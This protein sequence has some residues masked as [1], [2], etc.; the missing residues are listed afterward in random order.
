MAAFARPDDE[1][2][3]DVAALL[4]ELAA[5]IRT[6]SRTE[7]AIRKLMK[8][9]GTA[10]ARAAAVAIKEMESEDYFARARAV[11]ALGELAL[12]TPEILAALKKALGDRQGWVRRPA[13]RALGKLGVAA[14]EVV[15]ALIEGLKRGDTEC[16]E[17]IAAFGKDAKAAVPH[18]RVMMRDADWG[19]DRNKTGIAAAGALAR[20]V[21]VAEPRLIPALIAALRRERG[22]TFD[23][24]EVVRTLGEIGPAARVA[25]PYMH[26]FLRETEHLNP[27]IGMQAAEA[28]GNLGPAAVPALA[29]CLTAN[30][31][32]LLISIAI[33]KALRKNGDKSAIPALMVLR[34]DRS[35]GVR[36]NTIQTV[37]D[38]GPDGREA[39]PQLLA[40]LPDLGPLDRMAWAATVLSIDPGQS[41]VV[42]KALGDSLASPSPAI[43][44]GT[45]A[46]LL[47]GD[48]ATAKAGADV[49]R[50]GMKA[51]D[52]QTRL[53][54]IG[55]LGS[56]RDRAAG[57]LP[58]IT[59]LVDDPDPAVRLT[60][61]NA[62][63]ALTPAKKP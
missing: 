28:L 27:I 36:G 39:V 53:W 21:P 19:D 2:P 50:D 23:K 55:A 32:E 35:P 52:W 4:D 8:V 61:R 42:A 7:G 26:Q 60:A 3:T 25:I 34:L 6:K 22:D 45:A 9:G 59:A 47:R 43:R 11:E 48:A 30:R 58:E 38:L 49:I 15:P 10:P 17:A 13:V 16:V 1:K 57:L 5:G 18:L 41:A 56:V 40:D 31:F 54:A 62:V 33:I 51:K 29:D 44:L 24:L 14:G 63:R 20:I 12:N 37:G 46:A